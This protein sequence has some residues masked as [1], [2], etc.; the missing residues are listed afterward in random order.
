MMTVNGIPEDYPK[1]VKIVISNKDFNVVARA[2]IILTYLLCHD[3][4]LLATENTIHLWYSAFIPESLHSWIRGPLYEYILIE[5]YKFRDQHGFEPNTI[6]RFFSDEITDACSTRMTRELAGI[7]ASI[8]LKL[9]YTDW[10]YLARYLERDLL[11]E[12]AISARNAVVACESRLD[13]R[14]RYLFRQPYAERPCY[15]R[16]MEEGIL[17][18]MG[19][20]SHDIVKPN[21]TLFDFSSGVGTWLLDDTRGPE[22]RWSRSEFKKTFP[23]FAKNDIY[24]KLFYYLQGIITTFHTRMRTL[25]I[26]FSIEHNSLSSLNRCKFDRILLPEEETHSYIVPTGLKRWPGD[27]LNP[28]NLKSTIITPCRICPTPGRKMN[29]NDNRHELVDLLPRYFEIPPWK[30]PQFPIFDTLDPIKLQ[31]LEFAVPVGYIESLFRIDNCDDYFKG[32]WE[33]S[34]VFR[35]EENTIV[36]PWPYFPGEKPTLWTASTPELDQDIVFED[37]YPAV[38]YIEWDLCYRYRTP[39]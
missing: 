6:E 36:E 34:D 3:D 37:R 5:S 4:V 25:D 17:L 9:A 30:S 10:P 29:T 38:W 28:H 22:R 39:P 7:S 8:N 31:L 13:N 15:I 18:P 16:F 32:T 19:R 2:Y 21:V 33:R 26:E 12:E 11:R 14:E 35:K 27:F 1:K 24:G 23:G 20:P